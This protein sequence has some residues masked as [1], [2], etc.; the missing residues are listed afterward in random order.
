MK[1]IGSEFWFDA[2]SKASESTPASMPSAFR[3]A[4]FLSGRTALDFIIKDIKKERPFRRVMLPSYCCDSMIEPFLANEVE[5]LFYTVEINRIDYPENEADGVLLLDYFGYMLPDNRVIAEAERARGKVVIYDA[6]HK[7]DSLNFPADYSFCSFRK[8]LFSNCA[9]AKKK[10]E[11]FSLQSP[12]KMNRHY[13]ELRQRAAS[14]KAD[15]MANRTSL[16]ESFLDLYAKAEACLEKDYAGYGAEPFFPPVSALIEARRRN[17]SFLLEQLKDIPAITPWKAALSPLDA[18]LF[19]PILTEGRKRDALRKFL[20]ENRIYCPIHW[21]ITPLHKKIPS[22]YH[23]ELSLICDQRY[24]LE[25][26]KRQIDLIKIFFEDAEN[27]SQN[28]SY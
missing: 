13:I 24:T 26:M 27:E 25:D 1:E 20:I 28:Y 19:V 11:E 4:Y 18:P 8:W 2:F 22:L 17:A 23:Q 12:R 7:I 14:E 9:V 16:K 5:P 10:K 15:Y 21:P 3:E 6:T